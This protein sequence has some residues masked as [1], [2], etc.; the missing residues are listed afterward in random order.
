MA[1]YAKIAAV[2]NLCDSLSGITTKALYAPW[3]NKLLKTGRVIALDMDFSCTSAGFKRKLKEGLQFV[4]NTEGPWLIH[5]HAGVD[6]TGFVSMVLE[7][8]MGAAMDDVINDYLESFSSGFESSIFEPNKTDSLVALQ[9]L[10]VM[11]N[12]Q[13]INEHNLQ[14]IA[15]T[16]LRTSIGLSAEE[17]KLLWTKLTEKN[18]VYSLVQ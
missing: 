16:Y 8:F 7:A 9:L 17:T 10:S 6:R 1:S 11:S 18:N 5:C 4:I 15:E 12:S 13:A 3:Y 14:R 2:I